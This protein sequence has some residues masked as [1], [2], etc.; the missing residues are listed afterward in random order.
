MK[1]IIGITTFSLLFFSG[2]A[3]AQ[4]DTLPPAGITP[5]SPFFFLDRFFEDIGSFFIFDKAGKAR[6]HLA[7]AEERLAE[8]Q[9]LAKS[10]ND[11]TEEV[12]KLFEEQLKSAQERAQES[13]KF[14]VTAKVAEA[15]TKHI[16]VLDEIIDRVPR[17]AKDSLRAAKERS[18][19]GQIEAL[20][21]LAKQDPQ[22]MIGTFAKA[23]ER[24]LRVAQ[25]KAERGSENE[26]KADE[27]AVA[28][29]EYDK[30]TQ[31]GGEISTMARSIRSRDTSIE[32]LVRKATSHHVQVLEEIRQKLPPQAQEEFQVALRNVRIIQGSRPSVFAPTQQQSPAPTSQPGAQP[33][34]QSPVP[35]VP[36]QKAAPRQSP[37]A[38]TPTSTE[39]KVNKPA[40]AE[41]FSQLENE[42]TGA[43]ASG[44]RLAPEHFD[45]IKSDL[46]KL[47][48]QGY[49]RNEV[50]R[51]NQ[52]AIDLSPHLQGQTKQGLTPSSAPSAEQTYTAITPKSSCISNPSPVFTNHIT[53]LSKVSYVV[54][55]P[56]MGSGPSL[57]THS[58]IGTNGINVPVYAPTALTLKAGAHYVGGPYGFE[59]RAGCEVT[60]RFG[61]ITNPVDVLKKLLPSEPQPDSRT[62]ELS[63]VSFAA[64][65]LIAYT[66]GTE[67]AGNWD[68]G[69][70]NSIKVNRYTNDPSWN[71]ST[72]YTTAVCPFDYFAPDLKA[73]YVAKFDS[74][75]LGGN[76]PHGESFCL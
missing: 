43:R 70:Y 57:K 46:N 69:V 39:Q 11:N 31:F 6:H 41:Q 24:R 20:R 59:F 47:E 17:Q 28:L 14:D 19:D 10:G 8:A 15:A 67:T 76:P 50:E 23:A 21:G 62:Q 35:K 44:S 65:D 13:G 49:P 42:L 4:E 30:Y 2:V 32:D 56:T 18:V 73:G 27:A 26:E 33:K 53:D 64:G 61:H 40:L 48:S 9:A 75:I 60:V 5:E 52:M 68:F 12:I 16:S 58:Y 7:L 51:L 34:T 1:K 22:R 25:S 3:F 72:V 66:T 71:N 55:P 29:E 54:P 37:P 45:R 36:V 63:P 74:K 38:P